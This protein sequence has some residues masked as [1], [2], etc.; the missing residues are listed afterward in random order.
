MR[1]FHLLIVCIPLFMLDSTPPVGFTF[2]IADLK[3]NEKE[4]IKIC[5]LQSGSFSAFIGYDWLANKPGLVSKKVIQMLSQFNHK[6]FVDPFSI[7]DTAIRREMKKQGIPL[8]HKYSDL[9]KD[10]TFLELAKK[11]VGN[12]YD[13]KSYRVLLVT[14]PSFFQNIKINVKINKLKLSNVCFI[15]TRS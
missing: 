9:I 2:M 7:E 8:I 12:P 3:H 10:K 4:G 5:E 6:L 13:L 11:E 14:K 1:L 15:T